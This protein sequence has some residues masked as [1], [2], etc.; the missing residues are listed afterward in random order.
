MTNCKHFCLITKTLI[1]TFLLECWNGEPDNRPSM[2]EVSK[3]LEM[4]ISQL[5][6]AITYQKLN[7][8]VINSEPNENPVLNSAETS[9]HGEL[10]QIIQNFHNMNTN[11]LNFTLSDEQTFNENVSSEK[12]VVKETITFIFKI[13]NE[14]KEPTLRKQY[15]LDYLSNHNINSLE[16]YN[17]LV[18]NQN[19]SDSIFLLG[20]FN[21][22]GIE[23]VVNYKEACD[24]FFNTSEKN[25][26]LAEYYVGLCYL[27]GRR[28]TKNKK[29]AFKYFK[30]AA[31]KYFGAGQ[32]NLG[33]CYSKG[34]GIKKNFK[35]AVYWFE[36]A[37]NNG[38][39]IAMDSLGLWRRC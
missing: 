2:H 38:N 11:D 35:M 31:N 12:I 14:G 20:Y 23:T 37:A 13:C 5:N 8:D 6:D 33:Y 24:L 17:W 32:T 29:L 36:K 25:H 7:D 27:Y 15:T 9:S 16:I 18:N 28:I 30:K 19:D 39:V 10:S 21:F 26:T 34:I 4:I 1:I 3:R 22:Y